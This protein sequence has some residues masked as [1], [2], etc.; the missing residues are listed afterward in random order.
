[1]PVIV[2]EIVTDKITS[3]DTLTL[4]SETGDIQIGTFAWPTLSSA[5]EGS[6]LKTNGSGSLSFEPFQIRSVVTTTA[7]TIAAD[8]DIVA[9]T[10]AQPATLTLPDPAL[11]NE[12]NMIYVVKEIGGTDEIT[13][14][15]FGTELISGEGSTILSF[16]FGTV[17]LYTNKV[18]WFALF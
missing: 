16:S 17:K 1:M 10:I 9:I 8:D 7:Y 18:N 5:T 2:N 13:I 12:G 11:K 14:L 3:T 15:P 6:V 4:S